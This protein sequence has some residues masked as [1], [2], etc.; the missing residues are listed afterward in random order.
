MVRCVQDQAYGAVVAELYLIGDKITAYPFVTRT[1][2]GLP[3]LT[4]ATIP[5]SPTSR[6]SLKI[7]IDIDVFD[8]S[9]GVHH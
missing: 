3:I 7:L 1:A 8:N 5:L 9:P 2:K 6:L 4:S